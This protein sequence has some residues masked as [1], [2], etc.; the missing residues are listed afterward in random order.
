MRHARPEDLDAVEGLLGELREIA[1]LKE[2]K[3]GNFTRKS[4]AFLHFHADPD[5][6]FADVREGSDFVRYR[7]STRNEQRS[8]ARRVRALVQDGRRTSS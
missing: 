7:V 6:M 8:F 2:R 1:D 3:R 4:K 5:G